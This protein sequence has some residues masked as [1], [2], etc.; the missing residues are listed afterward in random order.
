MFFNER[1][2]VEPEPIEELRHL[3]PEVLES[4]VSRLTLP[5]EWLLVSGSEKARIRDG[6]VGWHKIRCFSHQLALKYQS[7]KEGAP[8][9][10]RLGIV[11]GLSASGQMIWLITIV[12]FHGAVVAAMLVFFF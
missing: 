2:I 10:S 1:Y 7:V 9:S 5:V 12:T 11:V 6:R 8:L 4:L 3:Q